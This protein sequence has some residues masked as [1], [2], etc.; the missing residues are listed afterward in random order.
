MSAFAAGFCGFVV[1]A[2]LRSISLRIVPP[3]VDA[4]QNTPTPPPLP[5][6]F[7]RL[8]IPLGHY[9]T[10]DFAVIVLIFALFS[11]LTWGNL[12][13]PEM[14][15][16]KISA[17][18]ISISIV[19]Q[20]LIAGTVAASVV[21]RISLVDWLGLRWKKWPTLV[22]I[23][24]TAVIGIWLVFGMITMSGYMEWIKSLGVETV[25]DSVKLLKESNDSLVI[26]LMGVAAVVVAPL[27]EEVVFRGYFYPAMKA[28][29]G[30]LPAALVSALVFSAAH[31][32]LAAL[33]PL[34]CFGLL[35]VWLYEKTGSIWTPMAV[36]LCFNG[37][38]VTLQLLARHYGIP[39]DG[40]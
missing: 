25:Q 12:Q 16:G 27:C 30:G 15:M 35:L 36:H 32:T 3:Q 14:E 4:P 18:G 38:T 31:G 24:P 10:M 6:D 39:L 9:R 26:V 11:Y 20:F 22:W 5:A 37:A 28:F 1:C 21:W 2:W 33:L 13:A 23:A 8:S 19:L 40:P 34:F 29:A 17:L 7:Q